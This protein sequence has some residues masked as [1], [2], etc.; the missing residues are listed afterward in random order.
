MTP[1]VNGKT[2]HFSLDGLYDGLLIMGDRESETLWNHV[3]GEAV[4][5]P[6]TGTRLETS[7][8]F[9]MNVAQALAMDAGMPVAVSERPFGTLINPFGPEF[10]NPAL[11]DGFE[12]TM[13]TE[14]PRRPRM[15]IGLGLW[16]DTAHRYYPM[17]AIR[18]RGEAFIDEVDGQQVLIYVQP[19]SA[20]PTAIFVTASSLTWHGDEIRLDT[21]VVVRAGLLFDSD[22]RPLPVRH[23]NQMFTRWYG[24]SLTFPG[25]DVF[26][27]NRSTISVTFSARERSRQAS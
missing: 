24:F 1:T 25:C 27:E 5:G 9:P 3:T 16:T 17:D 7:S 2:H 4:H 12:A 19:E 18:E 21:G 6:L 15:D 11:P 26:D 13:G 10:T 22:G 14:D 20:M 23:P 8:L